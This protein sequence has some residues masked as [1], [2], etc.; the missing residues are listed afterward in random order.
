MS[1]IYGVCG[2]RGTTVFVGRNEN[3]SSMVLTLALEEH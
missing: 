1:L 2:K 3:V